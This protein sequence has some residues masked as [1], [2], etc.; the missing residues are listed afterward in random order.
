MCAKTGWPAC[1]DSTVQVQVQATGTEPEVGNCVTCSG[2]VKATCEELDPP[3]LRPICS[4][5]AA[6]LP[7]RSGTWSQVPDAGQRRKARCLLFA[8]RQFH[9][10]RLI[11]LEK[12]L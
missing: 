3:A 6:H 12:S 4:C 7:N 1:S 2:T 10:K 9:R 8:Y 11:L 5:R